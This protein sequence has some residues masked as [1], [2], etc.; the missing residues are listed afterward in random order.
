MTADRPIFDPD[1][2]I[3]RLRGEIIPGVTTILSRAIAKPS[4]AFWRGKVGNPEASRVSRLATEHGTAVHA[5][6]ERIAKHEPEPWDLTELEP[7][8][9]KPAIAFRGW[10]NETVGRVIGTE[11]L[12]WSEKL[13]YAGTADLVVQMRGDEHATVIDLK[14]SKSGYP[15]DPSWRGQLSAYQVALWESAGIRATRRVVLQLPSNSPGAL[16]LHEFPRDDARGDWEA[17]RAA[18]ALYGW[19][20]RVEAGQDAPRSGVIR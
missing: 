7:A 14:T 9:Y 10:L 1:R 16:I 5:V 8:I 18:L 3:Y 2:H 20:E 17:F 4:L 15:P 19:L 13:W 12:V 11:L 6:C